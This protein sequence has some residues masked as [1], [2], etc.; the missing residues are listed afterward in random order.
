MEQQSL[1]GIGPGAPPPVGQ[2]PQ[3][4]QQQQQQMPTQQVPMQGQPMQQNPQIQ[5]PNYSYPAQG[6][7]GSA[8][9]TAPPGQTIHP[10]QQPQSQYNPQMGQQQHHPGM[11]MQQPHPSAGQPPAQY[12]P[13]ASQG[14]TQVQH[15]QGQPT[16]QV[17]YTQDSMGSW[18]KATPMPT[19]SHMP[20]PQGHPPPP[21]GHPQAPQVHPQAPQGHPQVPQGHPPP[22]PH[23][24]APQAH[25]QPPQGHMQPPQGHPPSQGQVHMPSQSHMTAPQGHQQ[26][27]QGQQQ[28]SGYSQYPAQPP[29]TQQHGYPPQH[30]QYIAPQSQPAARA[31]AP[32]PPAAG[33]QATPQPPTVLPDQSTRAQLPPGTQVAFSN[34]QLYQLR[35]QIMAYKMLAR[36]QGIPHQLLQATSGKRQPIG[37][38]TTL[39][40]S[41]PSVDT[42]GQQQSTTTVA[43]GQENVKPAA[44]AKTSVTATAKPEQPKD[45]ATLLKLPPKHT[46]LTPLKKP[47]GIDPNIILQER[48]NR[49]QARIAQRIDLLERLPANIAEDLRVKAT[50]EL[51]ALRLLG[52]QKQLR[53]EVLGAMKRDTT[54]ETALNARAYK[55]TKRQTLR[56][57]RI[58]ERMEKQQ[59][60]EAEKRRRQKHHDFLQSII[61][62]GKEFKDYH[63]NCTAKIGKLNKAILLYHANTEREQRK[64]QERIE[65]ERM[66]R[67]M[68]E[69]EEGYRKLIDEKKD[70]RL[71]YLLKQTDEY[72]GNIV[73]LV[74]EHK[75]LLAKKKGVRKK[76]KKEKVDDADRHI[77]VLNTE[78]GEVMTGDDAP[79]ASNLDAW[80]E[81]HPN[82]QVA[83]R[84]DSDEEEEEEEADESVEGS[85]E[86]MEEVSSEV[87][88]S[89]EIDDEYTHGGEGKSVVDYRS[90]Y[91]VA[92]SITEIITDQP[93]IMVSG[94]LKEYQV[95]GLEW[96]VSL[97]N[98]NLNGILADEMGLGKTIQTIALVCHLM[99]KKHVN[100]PFL[101]IVPLSTLSN[102]VME[103]EKWAPSVI[104]I[105]Y[106]GAPQIR[107]QLTQQL[108]GGKF[109]V[110]ITTYEYVIKDKHVLSK[111]RWKY[112]IVDEGHRMKN[113]HCKLTQVLNTYYLS[114][115]RL[116][117]TGTPLQNKLPE[118]W[119]LL[120][121]LLP[122]IFKSCTT[123]E[124]WFNAPFAM[125][126]EKV[127]LNEEETI[128]II[129]RL[130]KV[131]RP[132]LLRR[133][134][135]E[136]ESQLPEK[137][138]YVVKCDMSALQRLLYSHMQRNGLL[139]TDGSEKGKQGKG[140][141]KALMNTIM[142]LRK[143]CNHPFIFQHIEEA[144][145]E[146]LKIPGGIVSGPDLY[147][148]GGKFEL[149]D[150]IFPKLKRTNH[151]VLLFCQM[152]SLMTILEDYF[153]YRSHKYLRLD[154]T[155]KSDDRGEM[156]K[157]FNAKGSEYF[158]FLLST[159][160]GGLG[161]NLQ[162]A[163]TV[164]IFDS[165][166]NPHQ[167]V[168]AQDRA[169]RIGQTNEVR[170]LR[171]MTVNSVE[172]KILAAARY[173]LNVDSKVIQAGMFDQKSTGSERRALLSTLIR[174]SA[175]DEDEDEVPDDETINQM[176]ARTEEEFELFQ[177]MDIERRRAE[178]RDPNRKPRLMEEDE[179]PQWLL[180]TSEE[181]DK[182]TMAEESDK[183]FGRGSRVRK[184]VDYSESLTEKE[185]EKV[186]VLDF[187]EIFYL[188]S[189]ALAC[190]FIS[191]SSHTWQSIIYSF[192]LFCF[193]LIQAIQDGIDVDELEEQKKKKKQRKR[194][195]P[196]DEKM[197]VPGSAKKRR[198][199]P[200][201][202]KMTP[203]PP[204]LTKNMKKIIDHVIQYSDGSGR[205]LSDPFMQLP[206]RRDLPDYYE[207]IKKPVD[208]KKIRDRI[209]QHKY[210]CL[211]DLE[212]EFT[213]LCKNTQI[214]NVEGSLIYE[215]SIK[216]NTV[217]TYARE[218]L[219]KT[220][221]LPALPKH[222]NTP[223]DEDPDDD[224]NSITQDKD[225]SS[226]NDRTV[227][228][229]END[230]DSEPL[231]VKIRL[232]KESNGSNNEEASTSKHKIKSSKRAKV[233]SD[234]EDD[235]DQ[236]QSSEE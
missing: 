135:K 109:N 227:E 72:I 153:N 137:V 91:T 191:I 7:Y 213:S 65:K 110:V 97:Y 87:V 58:T 78:T 6:G 68:A 167:D 56:E 228:N 93:G 195:R 145:C 44:A 185:W 29:Q 17:Q 102:W 27:P 194:K 50:I 48:E 25:M 128:L 116:L 130:H 216:L 223:G 26:V 176:I 138:E 15:Y 160:A 175:E 107:K 220:G 218:T 172:E 5:P 121:F 219:E 41:S 143:I 142:Q 80:L 66:R 30:P 76:K 181:I 127:D 86:K 165:D 124:Q 103:F 94:Q 21:Q 33:S 28:M 119:A 75:V 200:P 11:G 24:P 82:F 149:L 22:Q 229:I 49:I 117:L 152:T 230:S 120:N 150:R 98:N 112:Q 202:E 54:L 192:L 36:Q 182:L 111:V 201:T 226:I 208:I 140:G 43:S 113:H 214:Y 9:S 233:I 51:K 73:Q 52:F 158:I 34:P 115:H 147:R 59:R 40:G 14:H 144:M 18:Q 114:P 74:Q 20:P 198:G 83:P 231:K 132:F 125:T 235:S 236:A 136:V 71:A 210:R 101:I 159:R 118:L 177:T 31:P 163:D 63:R 141:A 122:S 196:D 217:F 64:E 189:M 57:A 92:H 126:G 222:D 139:L 166:W 174:Q 99:E 106:K 221:Q 69:D 45:L 12:G 37:T 133:L 47:E 90:Y 188:H 204:K 209:K 131:L 104:K 178:A 105:A 225:D 70:K 183:L 190:L 95:K 23:M 123:F 38:G 187:F 16:Q 207:M 170:V 88:A 84:T 79:R 85:Q 193:F 62:H 53:Q 42:K 179:L 151:R 39:V 162:T 2:M 148:A 161:L 168:Q 134:K 211:D 1:G 171:L 199:R 169:H 10:T 173:K 19:Q 89:G 186:P 108:R 155:T 146:H 3:P 203:N 77:A 224:D 67:L 180:A 215:D 61:Q 205:R 129:R 55:R 197:E 100:G 8:P 32:P 234:D 184:E 206:A 60:M 157:Q 96:L 154:G 232:S 4:P 156:L 46:K 13:P 212:K 164:L 81:M 35:A